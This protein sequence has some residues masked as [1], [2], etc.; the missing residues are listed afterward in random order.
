ML[1]PKLHKHPCISRQ[2]CACGR[3]DSSLARCWT[4]SFR[5]IDGWYARV[6]E[7]TRWSALTSRRIAD[8]CR[9][10]ILSFRNSPGTSCQQCERVHAESKPRFVSALRSAHGIPVKLQREQASCGELAEASTPAIRLTWQCLASTL[11]C[12]ARGLS[13]QQQREHAPCTCA[14]KPCFPCTDAS[15][16]N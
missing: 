9:N 15:M 2:S 14:A 5:R 10:A 7:T 3:S 11:C 16:V 13:S 12:K 6:S 1:D 8:V 4:E